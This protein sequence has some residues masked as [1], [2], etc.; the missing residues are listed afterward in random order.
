MSATLTLE[1]KVR[2]SKTLKGRKRLERGAA[3]PPASSLGRVPHVS[4]LM[5]LAIKLDGMVARGDVK[6]Y[7]ELARL[8]HVSR[9]RVTQVMNLLNLAPEIQEA[10]LF[11]P[12]VECGRDR[13]K[14]WELRHIAGNLDW[15]KQRRIGA[16]VLTP[17]TSPQR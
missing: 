15:R 16:R 10:L 17:L 8:G 13:L 11:L 5:A 3:A 1:S 6:D 14:E 12:T 9:A 7:A 2:F 4:R